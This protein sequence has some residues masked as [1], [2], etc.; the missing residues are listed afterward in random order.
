MESLEQLHGRDALLEE[1]VGALERH[2]L[3]TLTGPGG[4]GKTRLAEAAVARVRDRREA[5]FVDCSTLTDGSRLAAALSAE[6]Q[7]TDERGP[8]AAVEAWLD[9]GPRLL[10]LDNL[11]QARGIGSSVERLLGAAPELR[12]LATSRAP[13]GVR[14]E[15]EL[16]V[17]PLGLPRDATPEAVEASPCGAMFLERAR[18]IGRLRGPLS[19]EQAADIATLCRRLDGLPLAIEL[20]SARTRVLSPAALLR[21][22]DEHDMSVLSRTDGSDRHR[23]LE[24]ILAWSLDLLNESERRVLEAAAVCAGTFGL[25]LVATTSGAR[26]V[27]PEVEALVSSGLILV[28]EEL[29]AEP[30]FR[31]LETIRLGVLGQLGNREHALRKAHAAGVAAILDTWEP[32]ID[33]P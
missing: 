18:G 23:S 8:E 1:L 3:V 14:G 7:L 11:E 2:R 24:A 25:D 15:H 9:G 20:A 21:R 17:P 30:R 13:L 19:G 10:A 28:D 33:S 31:L 4:T 22:L 29:E 16:P 5:F 6:L 26:D 12:V 27:L 32:R